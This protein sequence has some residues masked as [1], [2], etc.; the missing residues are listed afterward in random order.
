MIEKIKNWDE[1]LFLFL[2]GQHLDWLD[3]LM[4]QMTG[5]LIWLPLYAFLLFLI[6][7]QFKKGSVWF[8]AGVG[9][10]ILMADQ[11]TSGF[12]KPFFERLRPC[13]DLRW[14]E[15]MFNYGGCGGMYGFASSHAANSFALATYL[16]LIF[17]YRLKGFGWLFLWA[18]VISFTRVY[19]GVH[20]PLDIFM[21]A[22]VGILCGWLAWFV[23][24]KIKKSYAREV[25]VKN[26]GGSS[27]TLGSGN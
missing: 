6:V 2:N 16:T 11:S 10:A 8:L 12:M 25:R 4:E 22:L 17:R 19:L 14:E 15:Q 18:A 7:Q 20:Y 21:G 27:R 9:L 3:P 5:K 23:V 26:K 1:E 24:K 13:H